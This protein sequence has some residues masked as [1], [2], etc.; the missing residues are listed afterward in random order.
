MATD[1]PVQPHVATPAG[2]RFVLLTIGLLIVLDVISAVFSLGWPAITA[3]VAL[4]LVLDGIYI[5]RTGDR[6]FA[7]WL[8]FGVVA[9]FGELVADAWTVGT[10]TLVYPPDEPMIWN[11]PAYMPFA[12]AI[13][14]AQ[15]GY[16]SGWLRQ[17]YPLAVAT[18]ATA[19]LAGVNIP[20][21]EH[22]AKDANWWFYQDVP[23]LFSAPYYIIL[24]E[25]LLAIPLALWAYRIA[26]G[27]KL[28]CVLFGL[29]EG[30]VIFLAAMLSFRLVG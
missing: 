25:F 17:R 27:S 15:I 22:L 10:G 18:L 13:V 6:A 5:R 30:V 29:A 19:V 2:V 8:L 7:N 11:S 3:I 14:L 9:G 24:A 20:L 16:L 21:Y 1:T 28:D 12:W 23:M 26:R 4:V